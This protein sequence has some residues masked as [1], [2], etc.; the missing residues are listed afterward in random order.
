MTRCSSFAVILFTALALAGCGGQ[1]APKWPTEAQA[2][3][4]VQQLVD[5]QSGTSMTI[6]GVTWCVPG[7]SDNEF[8]CRVMI[9][10][11]AGN[12]TSQETTQWMKCDPSAETCRLE[13][14]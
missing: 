12:P 5:A 13:N 9:S 10:G 3:D 4:Q 6:D 2:R 14:E 7:I 1:N 11:I 8:E